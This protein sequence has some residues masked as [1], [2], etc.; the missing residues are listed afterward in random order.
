MILVKSSLPARV[1]YSGEEQLVAVSAGQ[2]LK[3]ET[4]PGGVDILDDSPPAGKRWVAKVSVSIDEF[5]V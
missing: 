2:S 3:M 5:D 1:K 4:S